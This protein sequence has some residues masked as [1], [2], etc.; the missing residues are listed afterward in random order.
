MIQI[1]LVSNEFYRSDLG[2]Y[3]GYG[4]LCKTLTEHFN[5]IVTRLIL[6]CS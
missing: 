2:G 4:Y 5:K 6:K 3:G 1:G